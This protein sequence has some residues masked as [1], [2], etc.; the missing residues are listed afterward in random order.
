M[1]YHSMNHNRTQSTR[2]LHLGLLLVALLGLAGGRWTTFIPSDIA[3]PTAQAAQVPQPVPWT[4]VAS[5]GAVDE[6][7]LGRYAA[8]GTSI[9]YRST[10][11]SLDPITVRYNVTD[12][13]LSQ[14]R[15]GWTHLELGSAVPGGGSFV[16]ATLFRVD[17]CTGAQQEICT[18]TND[19]INAVGVC[20]TCEFP[21]NAI[22]FSL[23][24]GY[25]YYVRLTLDRDDQPDPPSAYTLR[26]Y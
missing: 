3:S 10:S 17:R 20:T 19:G 6:E 15:P 8:I 25:L 22:D 16:S 5:T 12:L 23:M 26:L 7:S 14:P 13:S 4:A 18:T 24:P 1:H 21:A 2:R 11:Q 9:T